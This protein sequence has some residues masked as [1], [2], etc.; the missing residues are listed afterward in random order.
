M[1]FKGSLQHEYAWQQQEREDNKRKEKKHF[2]NLCSKILSFF[3]KKKK[4]EF[5]ASE[6]QRDEHKAKIDLYTNPGVDE[7]KFKR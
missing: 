5:G 2:K 3:W 1:T 7:V 4:L 6:S